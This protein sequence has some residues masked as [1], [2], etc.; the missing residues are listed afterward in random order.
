MTRTRTRLT[1][2]DAQAQRTTARALA[3]VPGSATPDELL[4]VEADLPTVA[5]NAGPPE[6]RI[7]AI[8]PLARIVAVVLVPQAPDPPKD[9]AL[10]TITLARNGVRLAP[11]LHAVRHADHLRGWRGATRAPWTV[12]AHEDHDVC[13]QPFQPQEGRTTEGIDVPVY[14]AR[15]KAPVAP[16][17]PI[18]RCPGCDLVYIAEAWLETLPC[19]GCGFDARVAR[20]DE[21]LPT[22]GARHERAFDAL[23]R[24]ARHGR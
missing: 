23:A 8:R 1:V 19:H 11:G 18:V 5:A 6:I 15:T 10:A 3:L 14:C 4:V 22:H 7:V 2:L 17:D 12:W 13:V 24:L 9:S 16:G 20:R 21:V